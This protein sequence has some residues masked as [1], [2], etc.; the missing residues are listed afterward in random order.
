MSRFGVLLLAAIV[1]VALCGS[2]S[3]LF[4]KHKAYHSRHVST[5]DPG[6]PLFLTPY[7]TKGEIEQGAC[8]LGGE[9]S[10]MQSLL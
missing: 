2:L 8:F 4:H 5:S 1:P 10:T 9:K 6:Q 3:G 7:I